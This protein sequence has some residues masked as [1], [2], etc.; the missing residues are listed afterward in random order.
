[1]FY[2]IGLGNPGEQYKNNRHNAGKLAL[3]SFEFEKVKII[4]SSEFMNNSGRAV[5]KF[6]KSKKTA[7]KLIVVYDD[8][9]LPIGSFKIS[10]NKSSGGHKGLESIIKS[11]K[12]KEFIRIRI[13]IAPITPSGKVKKPVGDKK[14][15]DYLLGDFKQNELLLLKKVFKK[16]S[17][18]I[19]CIIEEGKEK[20]M[21]LY[22]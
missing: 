10:F 12:T 1:M 22:N 6:I 14:V 4:E 8:I 9:D 17:D 3:N 15:L 7:E 13:G 21:N 11:I 16:V 19:V 18:A 2:I 5:V 20:A